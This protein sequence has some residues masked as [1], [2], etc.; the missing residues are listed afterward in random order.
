[1][2]NL[3]TSMGICI[4]PQAIGKSAVAGQKVMFNLIAIRMDITMQ[5]TKECAVVERKILDQKVITAVRQ[6]ARNK[7]LAPNAVKSMEV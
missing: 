1:M 7:Q 4:T 5:G 2:F 3:I 6:L